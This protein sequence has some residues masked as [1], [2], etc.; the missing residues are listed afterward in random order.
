MTLEDIINIAGK[1]GLFQIISRTKNG[2]IAESLENKKRIP[3]FASDSVSAFTD[4]SIYTKEDSVS[5]KELFQN[6]SKKESGAATSVDPNT[7]GEALKTYFKEV[8]PEYDEDQVYSSHIKKVLKWYNVLQSVK[9]LDE[10][11]KE[12][13]EEESKDEKELKKANQAKFDQK[14]K[15]TQTRNVKASSRAKGG[16][17]TSMPRKAV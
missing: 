1:P 4:I 8:L 17:Q 15:Q 10:L 9:L 13:E 5:L 6:I 3:V 16:A 14:Q 12:E 11:L 2:L 7:D